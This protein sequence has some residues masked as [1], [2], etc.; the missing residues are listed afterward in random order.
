MLWWRAREIKKHE[1]TNIFLSMLSSYRKKFPGYVT[2]SM[3]GNTEVIDRE[4]DDNKLGG[5]FVQNSGNVKHP[6]WQADQLRWWS[7]VLVGQ[8]SLQEKNGNHSTR[9][10]GWFCFVFSSS[11][12]CK[13]E[14]VHSER[15]TTLRRSQWSKCIEVI[16]FIPVSLF[17]G[18]KRRPPIPKGN[19]PQLLTNPNA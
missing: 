1:T 3:N 15:R 16:I 17:F 19:K 7:W 6:C 10:F 9:Q 5:S 8:R 11:S 14:V 2:I 4:M 13:Q 18:I 12:S